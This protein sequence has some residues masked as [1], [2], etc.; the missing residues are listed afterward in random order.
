MKNKLTILSIY[1]LFAA[2]FIKMTPPS[3]ARLYD[4]QSYLD[5]ARIDGLYTVQNLF[6]DKGYPLFLKAVGLIFGSE[7]ILVFQISNYVLWA[8]AS[9]FIYKSLNTLKQP[10]SIYAGVFMLFSPLFLTFSAKLY[11][12]PLASFG[13]S[14]TIYALVCLFKQNSFQANVVLYLALV[15]VML[16]KSIFLLFLIPLIIVLTLN[17]RVKSLITIALVLITITPS[18]IS[19]MGGGRSLYNLAIQSSKIEQTFNEITSCFPYYISYPL[20]RIVNPASEN[21]CRHNDPDP[22]LYGYDRNP[23]VIASKTREEGFTY[24]QWFEKI[25]TNPIKYF[26]ILIISMGNIILF[27]GIYPSIMVFIPFNLQIVLFVYKIM[28]SIGL[29]YFALRE[30]SYWIILPLTYF[31]IVAGNFPVESRYFYPLIPVVYFAAFMTKNEQDIQIA[32]VT[33]WSSG[34]AAMAAQRL[35]EAQKKLNLTN[36][37]VSA[38]S[39]GVVG[40]LWVRLMTYLEAALTRLQKTSNPIF[41]SFNVFPNWPAIYIKYI[42]PKIVH[43]HWI[44]AGFINLASLTTLNKPIVWTLHDLWPVLGAEHLPGHDSRMINGY[45][46]NNRSASEKGL[47]LNRRI[48]LR[49]Q[50]IL[51]KINVTFVAPSTY[52]Y[53]E[54]RRSAIGKKQKVE[55]IPNGIDLS[56]Y[57][58][59][60]MVYQNER[61]ILYV[62]L[63]ADVDKNKGLDLLKKSLKK[64]KASKHHIRVRLVGLSQ[65]SLPWSIGNNISCEILGSLT[66]KEL[67]IEYRKADVT[68]V[69]SYME[70]LSYVTLESMAVGTPVV[71][72]RVGGIPDLIDHKING[73]LAKPYDTTDL[74]NGITYLLSSQ[75]RLIKLSV[76]ARNKAR[77]F[78]IRKSV[79]AYEKLYKKILTRLV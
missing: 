40:Y 22:G 61:I 43:L 62:A 65:T 15:V 23:Y 34:G 66:P 76:E 44:G 13:V 25:L 9:Y 48:W 59:K 24:N 14:L 46:S 77:K 53:E 1:S 64:I 4:A 33:T 57:G 38:N 78:D 70:T 67:I 47:D 16:T 6:I 51:S 17:K 39:L 35:S 55:Y 41:K 72:F 30:K 75:K 2:L 69:P 60:D 12:E 74:A 79:A 58:A 54:F 52:I 73:Y 8:I 32:H 10:L 19:S 21:I 56:K 7:N 63:N 31:F 5:A 36:L 49:K 42:N 3:M 29:W 26:Y 28:L 27:E 11:S 45:L 68:I 71:A 50:D 20:G 18:I 37:V